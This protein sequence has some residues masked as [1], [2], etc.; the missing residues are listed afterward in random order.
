MSP[1]GPQ[2][3][4]LP[5][6]VPDLLGPKGLKEHSMGDQGETAMKSELG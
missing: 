5:Q 1:K 3:T 6:L 2:D 4:Y